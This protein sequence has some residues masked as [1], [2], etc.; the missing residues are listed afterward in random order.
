VADSGITFLPGSLSPYPF[1]VPHVR[2]SAGRLLALLK[3]A[4]RIFPAPGNKKGL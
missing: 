4:A 3:A 1:R 2:G